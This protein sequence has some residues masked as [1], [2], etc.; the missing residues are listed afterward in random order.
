[1]REGAAQR[2]QCETEALPHDVFRSAAGHICLL[3]GEA[4]VRTFE[5]AGIARIA[6]TPDSDGAHIGL[7]ELIK[8]HG[9]N[10]T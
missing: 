8:E 4:L 6:V 1:M 5:V 3:G 2:T 9:R 10:R 7:W